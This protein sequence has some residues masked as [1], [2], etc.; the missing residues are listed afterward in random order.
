MV[1]VTAL[2]RTIL[3][4]DILL[5]NGAGHCLASW[6]LENLIQRR[7]LSL[8]KYIIIADSP[9]RLKRWAVKGGPGGFKSRHRQKYI[10][11]Q[12]SG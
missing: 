10:K 6:H 2:R 5:I 11:V 8:N 3:L 1:R 9:L 12:A 4:I 7:F